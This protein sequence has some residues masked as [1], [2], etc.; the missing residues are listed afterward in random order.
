MINARGISPVTSGHSSK[1]W[2]TTATHI[3]DV[4]PT[5]TSHVLGKKLATMSEVGGISLINSS[6]TKEGSPTTMSHVVYKS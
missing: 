4:P 1:E 2:W 5:T 3:R 6:P